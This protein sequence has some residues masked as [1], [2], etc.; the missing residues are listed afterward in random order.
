MALQRNTKLALQML[1]VVI[2]MV[3]F[4]YAA[5]PLYSLF[6]KVTGYN[7]TPKKAIEASSQVGTREIEVRFNADI[8]PGLEWDFKPV[9]QH[10][11]VTTGANQL[12]YFEAENKS[13]ETITGTAVFNVTPDKAAKYFNKIQC[14]CFQEQ[15]LKPGQKVKMPVSFFIDTKIEADKNMEDIH[16]MTLSYT[17]FKA[18][19]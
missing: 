10:M 13:N 15:T 4:A 11:T 5:F 14:F 9:Q 16:A 3:C 2:G 8:E 12:A 18:K 17:F 6:C 19:K 7:G 1:G